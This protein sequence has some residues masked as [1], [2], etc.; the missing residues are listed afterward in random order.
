MAKQLPT[1]IL[2]R[3]YQI[4][5]RILLKCSVLIGYILNFTLIGME[6]WKRTDLVKV[7]DSDIANIS[8]GMYTSSGY[9]QIQI[10]SIY[11]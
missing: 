1:D 3:L 6:I 9:M 5:V 8:Y 4:L 11:S 7:D 10:W 2:I